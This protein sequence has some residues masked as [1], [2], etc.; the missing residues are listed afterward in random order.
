MRID[1][2]YYLDIGA[3]T[4]VKLNNPFKFY[5]RGGRGILIEANPHSQEGSQLEA[6]A[7]KRLERRSHA[8]ELIKPH[9]L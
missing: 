9:Y 4:P 8:P 1:N 3:N 7:I 6:R 2:L 5:Q